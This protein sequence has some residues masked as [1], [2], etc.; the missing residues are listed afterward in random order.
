MD[1]S[2]I[3][4]HLIKKHGYKQVGGQ[5][6]KPLFCVQCGAPA[7][8]KVGRDGYCK[9]HRDLATKRRE[10]HAREVIEPKRTEKEEISRRFDQSEQKHRE[11]SRV[12]KFGG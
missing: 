4:N 1:I 10:I 9:A 8:Y 2:L 5:V 7:L 11:A 12:K 3:K 6:F